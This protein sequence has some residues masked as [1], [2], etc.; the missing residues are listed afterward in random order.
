MRTAPRKFPDKP[1]IDRP[2]RDVSL[3]GPLAKARNMIEEP[4]NLG[5]GKIRIEHKAGMFVNERSVF[6]EFGANIRRAAA[7]PDDR[8]VNEP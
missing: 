7:L 4:L 3:G 2:E 6:F 1:A 5:A 8:M